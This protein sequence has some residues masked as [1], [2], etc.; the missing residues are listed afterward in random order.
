MPAAYLDWLA[1]VFEEAQVPYTPETADYLDQ[2][3]RK[4]VGAEKEDE[5][6]VFRRVRDR[7]LKHGLPG[8]QLLAAFLRDDV[9]SRRESPFRPKEGE[10]YYTNAYVPH[11]HLP[12]P[13]PLPKR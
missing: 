6:V 11:E 12:T 4:L 2:S 3:V 7:W 10:A 8:R 9:F 1:D 13:A 5:E